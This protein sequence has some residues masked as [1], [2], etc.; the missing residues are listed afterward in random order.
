MVDDV[1]KDGENHLVGGNHKQP[2]WLMMTYLRGV[3]LLLTQ[4]WR[5]ER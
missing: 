4:R 1:D 3:L 5:E 2:Q